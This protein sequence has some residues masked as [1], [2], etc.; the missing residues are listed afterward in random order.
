MFMLSALNRDFLTIHIIYLHYY[1][2]S[3]SKSIDRINKPG[4]YTHARKYMA[5]FH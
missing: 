1:L 4:E 3:T 5:N 2:H